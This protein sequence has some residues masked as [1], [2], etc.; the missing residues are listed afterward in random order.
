MP[1][2]RGPLVER[3]EVAPTAVR[4]ACAVPRPAPAPATNT[5]RRPSAFEVTDGGPEYV[6]PSSTARSD[7]ALF[8]ASWYV[9]H[10]WPSVPT[11]TT[12]SRPSRFRPTAGGWANLPFPS[13]VTGDI[14]KP[15]CHEW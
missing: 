8:G 13:A 2:A 3:D 5:S 10:R 15:F 14:T 12:S 7:H 11:A 4:R 1:R 6:W 9:C